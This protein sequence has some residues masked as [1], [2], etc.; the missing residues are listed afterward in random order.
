[1]LRLPSLPLLLPLLLL[2]PALARA[3]EPPT[4]RELRFFYRD[5][6]GRETPVD[7][8]SPQWFAAR[9]RLSVG[10]PFTEAEANAE[11]A[12]FVRTYRMLC[13]E[14]RPEPVPGGVRVVYVFE[15][16]A[17]AWE[18]RVVRRPGSP[19]IA[20]TSLMEHAVT[21]RR[22][23]PVD[24][25]AVNASRWAIIE[26]LRDRGRHFAAVEPRVTPVANRAGRVNVVFEVDR[27][28]K[29]VPDH[30]S[31]A[32]NTAFPDAELR[33][34][35]ETRVDHWYTW[36]RY[37]ARRWRDDRLRVRE[38]YRERGWEDV[39]V[40]ARPVL[41]DPERVRI[42]VEHGGPGTAVRS[43]SVRGG[44]IVSRGTMRRQLLLQPGRPFTPQRLAR[45]LGWLRSRY[46][47]AGYRT[48][49]KDVSVRSLP[50]GG[51]VVDV[52]FAR[53]RE[54]VVLDVT[55]EPAGGIARVRSVEVHTSGPFPNRDLVARV[56]MQPGAVFNEDALLRDAFAI[57]RHYQKDADGHRYV[58]VDSIYAPTA[59]G[60]RARLTFL[61]RGR[62]DHVVRAWLR[63]EIDEGERYGV[64]SVQLEGVTPEFERRIRER[65][66]LTAGQPFTRLGL[67]ADLRMIGSVYR[68]GG[69]ADVQVV[70][71]LSVPDP[72]KPIYAV[73]YAVTP[74]PLYYVDVI[75]PRGNDRT[76]PEVITRE[77]AI[78]PGDR[79]DEQKIAESRRRLL[80]TGHFESVDIEAVESRRDEPGREFKDLNVLL[81]EAVTRHLLIGAGASSAGGVF[82]DIRYRDTNFDLSDPPESW[83]DFV[84]GSAFTG[85]GQ[86]LTV[87]AQPG[88]ERSQFGFEFVEPW[89]ADVPVELAVG[90]VYTMRDW[91]DYTL[92]RLSGHVRLGRRF[93]KHNKVFF[94]ARGELVDVDSISRTAPPQIWADEGQH[95]IVGLS[96]GVARNTFDR[97]MLPTKGSA[98]TLAAELIGTPGPDA[99]KLTG[100]TRWYF[101]LYEAEDKS[102]QVISFWGEAAALAG[103]RLP[104]FERL[105]AGGIGSVRGF[106]TR[107]ISPLDNRRFVNPRN[108]ALGV[109]R[110][111]NGTPVGGELKI[112]GGIEYLI[113]IIKDRVRGVVFLDAGSVASDTT[114]LGAALSD[115]RVS[116][117][118]GVQMSFPRLGRIPIA[119]YLGFPLKKEDG[120]ETELVS[121]SV[122]I[123]LP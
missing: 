5:A 119:L 10:R 51:T 14:I 88:T 71:R 6:A 76:R 63:M 44:G 89:L 70:E 35:I 60:Y 1:L 56:E 38:H 100:Q 31:F 46:L 116:T 112:E 9:T 111:G 113:P 22:D 80:N 20:E 123:L 54:S 106:A 84:S 86:K 23:G 52:E 83:A 18:V 90:G 24:A 30:I 99:V 17:R 58:L 98:H 12:R 107:G 25:A 26:Y 115:L 55:T 120:D 92:S 93:G 75:R 59:T 21:L 3:A 27:G 68:S 91:D 102:R 87:F 53:A 13:R 114:G 49:P 77:M 74:G 85:G 28:P 103:N 50:G 41:F 47:A 15:R 40:T 110:I 62:A 43:L 34:V 67:V 11:L 81:R 4:I 48:D 39:K 7:S 72:G 29:V 73:T 42:L 16:T 61:K 78:R 121:F 32:G 104:V 57:A 8:P 108:R 65:L 101:T 95:E 66:E 117:G 69:H 122:G 33:D 97:S 64:E 19:S 2:A 36:R 105:Y 37:V 96:V 79:Y 45:D 82:G 109:T 94:G 118:F